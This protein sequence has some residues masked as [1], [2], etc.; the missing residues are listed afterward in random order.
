VPTSEHDGDREH[1]VTPRRI[2]MSL[3]MRSE[4]RLLL[5]DSA[6][7]NSRSL[8]Q[9]IDLR[10]EQAFRNE[11]SLLFEAWEMV[12]GAQGRDFLRLIGDVI[13]HAPIG[14]NW[15]NDPEEYALVSAELTEIINNSPL[16]PQGPVDQAAATTF[17]RS[18]KQ[19]TLRRAFA[20]MS[21]VRKGFDE[22]AAARVAHWLD[23]TTS[24]EETP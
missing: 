6:H 8:S 1:E 21:P 12:Y 19:N 7:H 17:G 3:R 4:L 16:R 13:R 15:L 24:P 2:A 18:R 20:P 23:Q 11:T 5:E 9:E 10:L 22:Q 14:P